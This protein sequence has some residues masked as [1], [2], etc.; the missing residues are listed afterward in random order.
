[1]RKPTKSGMT[2][3]LD[4]IFSLLVRKRGYCQK[5]NLTEDS[6]LQ[7]AHIHSRSRLSVRWDLM[8]AF[9]LCSGCHIF[10]AHKHPIEF[11]EFTR[12]QLGD[13]NYAQLIT[14]ANSIKKWTIPE[15][16]NLLVVLTD[17]YKK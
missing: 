14:R 10:W 11:A 9:C 4:K 5:C 15:M 13:Y 8:N 16:Q 3:K 1:M 12:K 6:K 7:C 2:R 17:E